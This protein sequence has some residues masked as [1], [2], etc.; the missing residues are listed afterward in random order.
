LDA[1][2]FIQWAQDE[3]EPTVTEV[4]IPLRRFPSSATTHWEFNDSEDAQRMRDTRKQNAIGQGTDSDKAKGHKRGRA[5]RSKV[6]KSRKVKVE[7][8]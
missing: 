8:I 1:E 2:E 7:G 5:G 4:K 6:R 3:F